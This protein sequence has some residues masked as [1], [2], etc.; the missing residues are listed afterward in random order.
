MSRINVYCE[1]KDRKIRPNAPQSLGSDFPGAPELSSRTPS[2]YSFT[3]KARTPDARDGH[4]STHDSGYFS[5]SDVRFP[6]STERKKDAFA[7]GVVEA[8]ASDALRGEGKTRE[9][10][11]HHRR[12]PS[13]PGSANSSVVSDASSS[14]SK[15]GNCQGVDARFGPSSNHHFCISKCNQ[16]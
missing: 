15:A 12:H 13:G 2:T 3:P 1:K 9:G 4:R 16:P 14:S 7:R 10:S 11:L 8:V 5:P 6:A